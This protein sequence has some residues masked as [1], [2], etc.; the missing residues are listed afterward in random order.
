[1]QSVNQGNRNTATR[2]KVDAPVFRKNGNRI[3]L[4]GV[5]LSAVELQF[6]LNHVKLVRIQYVLR[7][8]V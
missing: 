3:I 7:T 5:G 8:N 4:T 6:M 2:N 1:M